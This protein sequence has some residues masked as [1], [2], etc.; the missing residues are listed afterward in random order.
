MKIDKNI[1][2]LIESLT[3]AAGEHRKVS[4]PGRYFILLSNS[5]ATRCQIAVGG[6][7]YQPWP[8]LYSARVEKDEDYFG[9]VRFYNPTAASM[10][11][12]YIIS[13]LII[14]NAST[15]ITG[16]VSVIDR[17]TGIETPAPIT[18]LPLSIL[19][20]NAAAVDKGGGKVGIPLTSQPFATGEILTISGTVNYNG[21]AHVVDATSSA[22]EVV[23][24]VAYNAETFDGVD[25]RIGLTDPRSAAANADRKEIVVHNHNGTYNVFWGDTNIDPAN[26]R[27]IPIPSDAAYIVPNTGQ[28]FF[29]A[30][31]GA[32]VAGCVISYANMT[33]T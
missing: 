23:I 19:I 12:E 16:D 24:T 9:Q 22:D 31:D 33:K 17:S 29:A 32:G 1:V 7:S 28:I 14:E 30:E 20:N 26:N 8:V 13:N 27:G 25:D 5:L 10:T 11:V 6:S 4:Q 15:Q 18:A 3:L 2:T 21:I